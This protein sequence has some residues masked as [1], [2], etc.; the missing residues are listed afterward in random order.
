MVKEYSLE[1]EKFSKKNYIFIDPNDYLE[2]IVTQNK[3]KYFL[4]FIHPNSHDG[5]E[6]Y[7]ESIF[8]NSN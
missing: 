2:K 6:L 5:I 8:V 4:D 1:L 7:S 3:S